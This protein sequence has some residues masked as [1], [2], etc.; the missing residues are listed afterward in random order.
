[1]G[2][3]GAG[4]GAAQGLGLLQRLLLAQKDQQEQTDM[5]KAL[6]A[7]RQAESAQDATN[8]AEGRALQ[9]KQIDLG[10]ARRRDDNNQAGVK[11]MLM[12]R[13]LMDEQDSAQAQ[14]QVIRQLPE[15]LQ[16]LARLGYKPKPEDLE[17]PEQRTARLT[18][19]DDHQVRQAGRIA[20]AQ[21]SARDKYET[22]PV[23]G[24]GA[25]QPQ[26]GVAAADKVASAKTSLDVL[27]R[28]EQL[29]SDDKVGPIAGR[30]NAME[31]GAPSVLGAVMPDAPAG[32]EDF[33]AESATLKNQVIQAVTGAAVSAQEQVRI[34]GQI[35]Q[36]TDTPANWKAKAAATRRNL[37]ALQA[38]I[39]AGPRGVP[40]T[41][42]A[43][44]PAPDAP[45]RPKFTIVKVQ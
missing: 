24:A 40:Q 17:T 37:Q 35:P 34:M 45:A 9:L 2:L 11:D 19:E 12:Q 30:Y 41:A 5:A 25:A 32:F 13:Q 26:I 23:P 21:A 36:T 14:D 27:S 43:T 4:A 38:N 20:D 42:E 16:G 28:L 15:G 1:M 3:A 44:V 31:R 7:Q 39:V 8:Q 10:E 33:N 6:L 22:K 29:Y 18:A